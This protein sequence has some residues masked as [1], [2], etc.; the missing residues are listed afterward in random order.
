VPSRG[1]QRWGYAKVGGGGRGKG[2][3]GRGAVYDVS[4]DTV[5]VC[6]WQETKGREE[7][8]IETTNT[9]IVQ[10]M[11]GNVGAS[12]PLLRRATTAR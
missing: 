1:F 12:G 4:W 2:G 10:T 3:E 11:R 5:L 6:R 7:D 9:S 8:N